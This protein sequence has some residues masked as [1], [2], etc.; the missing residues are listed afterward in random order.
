MSRKRRSPFLEHVRSVIRLR[1]LSYSTEKSYVGWIERYIRWNGMK[2][3]KDLGSTDVKEF[4]TY[5][6]VQRRVSAS[7]QNQALNALVFLYKHVLQKPLGNIGKTVRAQRP[8]LLPVVLTRDEVRAMFSNLTGPYWLIA[9]LLYGSGLRLTECLKLRIKDIE[10]DR[11]QLII[12]Q[13]KGFKDRVAIMPQTLRTHLEIQIE[14]VTHLYSKDMS[15]GSPGVSLPEGLARKYPRL[16]LSLGWYYLFPAPHLSQDP[17]TG[18]WFRHHLYPDTVRRRL[19]AAMEKACIK[20]HATSHSLRHSYASHSLEDGVDI[21]TLQVLL[22]HNDIRTTMI[23]T[24]VLNRG[25]LG[26]RSP[27]DL[28]TKSSRQT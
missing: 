25:V 6:A 26:A 18:K 23:Y 12:R 4:L 21:R 17:R 28:W 19:K 16:S 10:F 2:H 22:G 5:L 8:K 7:T 27:L 20:K 11:S 14:R 13:S 15:K 24:H 9:N 3:P 1:Q